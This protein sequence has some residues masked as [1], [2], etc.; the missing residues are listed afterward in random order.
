[1]TT[2]LHGII[3]TCPTHCRTR[4]LCMGPL[5]NGGHQQTGDDST[6]RGSI[7]QTPI[8]DPV[9]LKYFNIYSGHHFTIED[10]LVASLCFTK[11]VNNQVAVNKSDR[12]LPDLRLW[13]HIA[14]H[15]CPTHASDVTQQPTPAQP[16]PLTSHSSPLLPN[17][18]L[19]RHTAAHSCPTYASDVTQQPLLP[20]LRIW[21]HTAVHSCPTY[22]SDVTQQP[23]PAQ[24]TPLTSHSS[25]S[26]PTYASDV[27]QQQLLPNLRLWRH[28]AATPA[29]PTPLTSH[30]SPLLPNLHLWRHTAAHSCPTYASDVTQ[31]PLLPNLHLWRHT[32]AHSCPTYTSDVT[33]QPTPAQPTPLTSH[34]SPLLP[35]TALQ[36]QLPTT[37][38]LPQNHQGV[39]QSPSTRRSCGHSWCL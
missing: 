38:L 22:T 37:V 7:C 10:E 17:I 3:V 6:S 30:S 33:Q 4:L 15:S 39:E 12:L 24:P 5:W 1:M 36:H 20:N 28:T 16:T 14:A 13:R 9:S 34:S 18:H 21:R 32:A 11:I 35:D 31:Q 8:P 23:T 2:W 19:W 25:H 27:T 29:Q 26:C